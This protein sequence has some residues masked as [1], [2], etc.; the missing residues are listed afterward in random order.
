MSAATHQR[1]ANHLGICTAIIMRLPV[2]TTLSTNQLL[3][4]RTVF[5]RFPAAIMIA[6]IS[7]AIG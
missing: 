7:R 6:A 1:L 3:T 2:T 5:R 4:A